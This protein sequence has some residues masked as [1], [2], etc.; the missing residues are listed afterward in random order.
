MK[1]KERWILVLVLIGG[2]SV[3]GSAQNGG[4]ILGP[5]GR[6]SGDSRE[7]FPDIGPS[8]KLKLLKQSFEQTQKDTARLYELAS[9]LKQEINGTDEDVLSITVMKK[10]EEIEKLAEK[11]KNRMKNL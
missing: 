1:S 6:R 7:P 4:G 9:E 2:L 5:S 10:A 8:R 11:I 3:G